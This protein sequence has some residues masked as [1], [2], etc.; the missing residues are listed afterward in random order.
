MIYIFASIIISLSI[1]YSSF[2][3]LY[4]KQKLVELDLKKYLQK[5]M[6]KLYEICDD[7]ESLLLANNYNN[8]ARNILLIRN[9]IDNFYDDI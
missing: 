4:Y 5:N 9:K 8:D 6:N 2:N 1:V 7:L 3:N